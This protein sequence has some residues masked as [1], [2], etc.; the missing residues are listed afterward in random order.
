MNYYF[1]YWF[2]VQFFFWF[3]RTN[4]FFGLCF[5]RFQIILKETILLFRFRS[6]LLTKSLLIYFPQVTKMFQF[7]WF[8]SMRVS[9]FGYLYFSVPS[10]QFS[11]FASFRVRPRHPWEAL[12]FLLYVMS[13]YVYFKN[14]MFDWYIAYLIPIFTVFSCIRC[15]IFRF[16][17]LLKSFF[18]AQMSHEPNWFIYLFY[19]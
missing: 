8:F 15:F 13:Y 6:P 18:A 7:T 4:T 16:E 14:Y 2:F 17:M 1:T 11:L 9:P 10:V 5:I 19:H 12:S 3:Y